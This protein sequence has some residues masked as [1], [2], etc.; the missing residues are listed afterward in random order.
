[1]ANRAA[2]GDGVVH[3]TRSA[4]SCRAGRLPERLCR[5]SVSV[6]ALQPPAEARRKP[7]TFALSDDGPSSKSISV[8]NALSE[9]PNTHIWDGAPNHL[10]WYSEKLAP[11]PSPAQSFARLKSVGFWNN[12]RQRS[13]H[14]AQRIQPSRGI[15]QRSKAELRSIRSSSICECGRQRGGRRWPLPWQ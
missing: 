2:G 6:S 11:P 15:S 8:P 3:A 5:R 4:R 1:M 9:R 13:P 14:F 10:F 7:P 12:A